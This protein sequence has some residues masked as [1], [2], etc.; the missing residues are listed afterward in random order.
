MVHCKLFLP[1]YLGMFQCFLV[2]FLNLSVLLLYCYA[3]EQVFALKCI[4]APLIVSFQRGSA[5]EMPQ[6]SNQNSKHARAM[7]QAQLPT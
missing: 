4:N 3:E 6:S 5:P 1:M 2:L 7:N